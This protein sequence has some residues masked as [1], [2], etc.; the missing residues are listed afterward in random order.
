MQL[1]CISEL[2]NC[3]SAVASV[4]QYTRKCDLCSLVA[5]VVVCAQRAGL[6]A[7]VRDE[8]ARGPVRAAVRAEDAHLLRLVAH[9]AA[10]VCAASALAPRV[11]HG[12]RAP[13]PGAR[14]HESLEVLAAPARGLLLAARAAEARPALAA[15]A[16]HERRVR[17]AAPAV[18]AARPRRRRR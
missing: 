4:I 17:H 18:R 3:E 10:A 13:A 1:M 8:L 16:A 11:P 2:L 7:A 12:A 5:V 14:L 6:A 15:E 9:R